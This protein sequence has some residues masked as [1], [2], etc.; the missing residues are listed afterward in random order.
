MGEVLWLP[1]QLVEET[2]L[3]CY[4]CFLIVQAGIFLPHCR[5]FTEVSYHPIYRSLKKQGWWESGFAFGIPLAK[6]FVST[7]SRHRVPLSVRTLMCTHSVV[8]GLL[9]E[10][11]ILKALVT[12][13]LFFYGKPL[14]N[15]HRIWETLWIV[16]YGKF[17]F[18][19]FLY[20]SS[21]YRP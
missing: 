5:L 15:C 10:S 13:E 14:L 16:L 3:L 17:C 9:P 1:W 21:R 7:L 6:V 19:E 11:Y 2:K 20:Y 12:K 4:I 8:F 18:L